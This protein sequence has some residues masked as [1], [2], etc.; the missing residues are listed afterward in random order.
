MKKSIEKKL[1]LPK[2]SLRTAIGIMKTINE[3]RANKEMESK[4]KIKF[5]VINF[6]E[7]GIEYCNL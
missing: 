4:I 7:D 1:P 6:K 2:T 5:L 3:H